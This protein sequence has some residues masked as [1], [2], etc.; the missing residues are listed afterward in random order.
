[1]TTLVV[2]LALVGVATPHVMRL[3][4]ARASTAAAVWAAALTLRSLLSAWLAVSILLVVPSTGL[5]RTLT[6]WCQHVAIT[7]VG[8]HFDLHGH[9]LG[10]AAMIVPVLLLGGS[11]LVAL[12]VTGR[13]ARRIGKDVRRTAIGEGPRRTVLVGGSEVLF[14]AVGLLRPRIVISAGALTKLDDAELA[15]GLAHEEG[16]VCRRH[17]YLLL[18]AE[19]CR[20]MAAW[21][22]GTRRAVAELRFHLERDAD[23][24]ALRAHDPLA[25]ASAICK[26]AT[27]ADASSPVLVSLSGGGAVVR[28]VDL[29]IAAQDA[30]GGSRRRGAMDIAAAL[31]AS[32]VLISFVAIPAQAV[33]RHSPDVAAHE[34]HHCAD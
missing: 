28:R 16:H 2:A 14:A 30:R 23:D 15:A 5:F 26:A 27:Q 8:V 33:K 22:P 17:Q 9:D 20:A 1:V 19:G 24:W 7:E 25:L 31:M 3:D 11:I 29:L 18:Y 13:A 10:A 4:G 12:G 34:L 32:L 21:I 6:H